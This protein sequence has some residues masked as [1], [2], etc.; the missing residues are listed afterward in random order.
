MGFDTSL[1]RWVVL[2]VLAPLWWPFVRILW[3]D[4]NDTLADE[5]GI[6]GRAPG[7]RERQRIEA[8]KASRPDPL[9]SEPWARAA[10]RGKRGL[11][12]NS[13]SLPPP[14]SAPGQ[15]GFGR[16]SRRGRFR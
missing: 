10:E 5:G 11:R 7:I 6:F 14:A 15:S 9:V 2:A 4:F 8:E 16:R 13:E 1:L 3:K 12:R